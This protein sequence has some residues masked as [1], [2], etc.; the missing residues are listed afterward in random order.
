MTEEN[1]T[2]DLFF[3]K[4]NGNSIPISAMD[5]L[6]EVVV[7]DDLAQPAMFVL[8]FVDSEFTLID[9]TL[10]KLGDDVQISARDVHGKTQ[11]L[12]KGEVTALEP[13]LTQDRVELIVRGYDRSHRLYRGRSTRSFLNQS[14]AKIFERVVHEAGLTAEVSQSAAVT[15]MFDYVAQD[16]L[17]DMDF[18]RA[19]AARTGYRITVDGRT[20][21]FTPDD[22]HT[23]AAPPQ[24][25]GTTLLSFRARLTAATQANEV[26]VRSWDPTAKRAVVGNAT[27]PTQHPAVANGV[28]GGD[29][30]RQAFSSAA[31]IIVCDQPVRTGQE[32]KTLAQA[33]LD[34]LAGD[35]LSIEATC[36]GEPAIRA[37][38]TVEL[39]HIG[40]RFSGV[41]TVTA[42]RHEYT[43]EGYRTTFYVSGRRP[44]SVLDP[45]AG[46]SE[47][48]VVHGV[49]VGL[50]TNVN[51][52]Q[53]LGRIKLKYPWF[54]EQQESEWVRLAAPGAGPQRGLMALPEVN[55]EMLVAFEHGDINRPYVL[56]GL[57]N[58]KDKPPAAAVD[59][60]GKV[61]LRTLCTRAGHSIEFLEDGTAGKGAIQI[62]TAAGQ[63]LKLS[64]NDKNI[65]I[66]SA[67]HTITLDDQGMGAV[68][69]VSGGTL[70]LRGAGSKLSF[71]QGSMELTGPGGAKLAFTPAG[72]ELTA[73]GNK[74][75]LAAV[76]AEVT[77]TTKLDLKAGAMVNV[78]GALVKIN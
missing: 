71:R 11:I 6:L 40:K 36:L 44:N 31:K 67:K 1:I 24:G 23:S 19:R 51:D 55:D 65:Q 64:D 46:L 49:A 38:A 20:V 70:E 75:A 53:K 14:D 8:R 35:Y 18:L 41:Y 45:A 12:M 37:G 26:E 77:G 50:V 52:P 32:A 60:Q 74:V 61:T 76:G 5:E 69:I 73:M 25:F 33:V 22:Q 43:D 39:Q 9:G 63:L 68:T 66:K 17:S 21:K 13:E 47:R 72:A 27:K 59:G 48:H 10:F 16:G 57:W 30:A 34:D 42:T 7:E 3:V 28:T 2:L 62:K 4:V 56:G 58:P 54:D 15:Q 29:A 78:Q